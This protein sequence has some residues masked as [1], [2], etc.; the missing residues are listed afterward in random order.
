MKKPLA[1][2]VTLCAMLAPC[3]GLA[4]EGGNERIEIGLSTDHVAITPD[5]SGTNLVIFGALDNIDPLINREGGYDIVVVLEG[6]S[7]PVIIRKK[8]RVVGMWINTQSQ[9]FRNVPS[10][11]SM[12]LTRNPQDITDDANY[13]W[14]SLGAESINMLPEEDGNA[15]KLTEEFEKA[16]VTK[17]Q[18][19]GLYTQR[20]GGVRFL[21]R[22]LFRATLSLAP[23]VPVGTHIAHAY[24]FRNRV[25]VT[26]TSA[27]LTIQK[28]GAEQR[29]FETAH[30][31]SLVYGLL[32]VA[33]AAVT[34]W[35]GRVLFRKD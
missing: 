7:R 16:L 34:G 14:L 33:L 12:A 8:T 9:E 3:A 1:A 20:V 35:L 6:P 32:A 29:I 4:Q 28:A 15:P 11:Y 19:A 13:K 25:F 30:D 24:L 22:N 23:N 5:F 17:K 2:L 26:E 10:S 31:H 21:S 27:P 18:D